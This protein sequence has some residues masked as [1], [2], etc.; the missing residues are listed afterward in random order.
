[1]E[2]IEVDQWTSSGNIDKLDFDSVTLNEI[3]G[4][5][6]ES[7]KVIFGGNFVRK[8][9]KENEQP[10]TG[11]VWYRKNKNGKCELWRYNFATT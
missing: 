6:S 9:V 1:M 2:I 8:T 4:G 5:D 7:V 3:K 10:D 11:N